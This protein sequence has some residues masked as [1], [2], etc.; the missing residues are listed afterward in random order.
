VSNARDLSPI[1]QYQ[2]DHHSGDNSE[3]ETSQ[4]DSHS[5][6][7]NN[8]QS[9][10]SS[11]DSDNDPK[12]LFKEAENGSDDEGSLLVVMEYHFR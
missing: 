12:R 6:R 9:D 10:S 3:A 11:E 1:R 8:S 2:D 4:S 7:E 5:I